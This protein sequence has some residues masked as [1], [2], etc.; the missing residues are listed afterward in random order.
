MAVP[1]GFAVFALLALLSCGY[2]DLFNPAELPE[3]EP[4]DTSVTWTNQLG[5]AGDDAGLSILQADDEGFVIAGYTER[6][7]FGSGDYDVW[8]LDTDSEGEEL[9]SKTFGGGGDDRGCCVRQVADGGYIIVGYTERE[10]L[11]SGDFDAWLIKTD[12]SG[13]EQWSYPFGGAGDDRGW[14]VETT[15]DGG[16]VIAG[17]TDS[18]GAS[19]CDVWLLKTDADGIEQWSRT[20]GPSIYD[21]GR[22]VRQTPD[23]GFVIAGVTA[24]STTDTDAYLIRTDADG[25]EQWAESFGGDF[26]TPDGAT[27]V[28]T[29]SD[30][31]YVLAGHK[32]YGDFSGW[33]IKTDGSGEKQWEELYGGGAWDQWEA[34]QKTAD[35]GCILAGMT[36]SSG[37]WEQ[38]WLV[39]TDADG[40]EQWSKSFGGDGTDWGISVALTVDGGYVLTGYTN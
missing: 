21:S 25:I 23:Q 15:T 18:L 10:P 2:F 8:L 9:W 16:Y 13:V 34:I 4:P 36:R 14:C 7:P 20:Y 35:G 1:A 5:G 6:E 24:N 29:E 31:G 37:L 38:A 19:P 32:W 3:P 22:C 33:L 17:E 28:A 30:G 12:A 27:A 11:G 40:R 39:K 26:D